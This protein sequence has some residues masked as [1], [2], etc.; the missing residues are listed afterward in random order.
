MQ[1][2]SWENSDLSNRMSLESHGAGKFV[3]ARGSLEAQ[4]LVLPTLVITN[5][6]PYIMEVG[7]SRG[8]GILGA[9]HVL[10][11]LSETCIGCIT[12]SRR[13]RSPEP[14]LWLGVFPCVDTNPRPHFCCP[15]P[16]P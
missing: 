9:I 8:Y 6:L 2:T 7:V 11:I 14:T 12:A 13:G 3:R 15:R 4:L 1:A 10:P 16:K 5:S